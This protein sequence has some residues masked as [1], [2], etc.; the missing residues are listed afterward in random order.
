MSDN[1]ASTA[2]AVTRMVSARGIRATIAEPAD[3]PITGAGA[4]ATVAIEASSWRRKRWRAPNELLGL[5]RSG[6][7]RGFP[8]AQKLEPLFLIEIG[9]DLGVDRYRL[10]VRAE[11]FVQARGRVLGVDVVADRKQLDVAA[12]QLLTALRQNV[13]GPEL[14]CVRILGGLAD[15][16]DAREDQRVVLRQ[17]DAEIL[18][19]FRAYQS[20][21]AEDVVA[22]QVLAR[23]DFFEHVAGA[24]VNLVIGRAES[25][26]EI[27]HSRKVLRVLYGEHESHSA[28]LDVIGRDFAL[29]LVD[30]GVD[31]LGEG[32]VVL[33]DIIARHQA[34]VVDEHRWLVGRA[35]RLIL[36][37]GPC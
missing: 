28:L 23:R 12:D 11:L 18:V 25:L 5:L 21:G 34:L 8:V 3:E 4:F 26:L 29:E 16:Q 20:V 1:G 27:L 36:V 13:I 31:H 10:H 22:E 30:L 15:E 32:S 9:N 2:A 7:E 14:R 24:R 17:D 19:F 6:R 33:R 37:D 35:V